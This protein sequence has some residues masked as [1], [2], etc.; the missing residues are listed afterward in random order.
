MYLLF[1][2]FYYSLFLEIGILKNDRNNHEQGNFNVSFQEESLVGT[3]QVGEYT[4]Q[5]SLMNQLNF[6]N[7]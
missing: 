2:T 6:T 5:C 3:G 4:N 7:T 1:K